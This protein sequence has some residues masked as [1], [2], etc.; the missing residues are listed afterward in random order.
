[1]HVFRIAKEK[2]IYDLEGK[3]AR[4]HGGRWNQKG[5]NVL[6]TS[7]HESV[8]VLEVLAHTP[9]TTIPKDLKLM[10]LS[11]PDSISFQTVDINAL[12]D[13]WRKYP[14]PDSLAERGTN[15]LRSVATLALKVPSLITPSEHNILL[16]PA[17]KNFQKIKPKEVRDFRFDERLTE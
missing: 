3:G 17:H 15:W 16:N 2:Y 13:N 4:I 5:Y 11:I 6:Y 14:A 7:E 10:M 8:A 1:M 9:I 12:P